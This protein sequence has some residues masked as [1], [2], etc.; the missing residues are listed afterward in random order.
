VPELDSMMLFGA[1]FVGLVGF[2]WYQR[3]KKAA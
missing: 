3:R 1:G 2:G